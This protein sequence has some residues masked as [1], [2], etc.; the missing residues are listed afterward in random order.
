MRSLLDLVCAG[1]VRGLN[2]IFHLLPIEFTLWLARRCSIIVYF[3]NRPRRIVAYTNLRAAFC[4]G[5]SPDELRKLTKRVYQGLA[6]VFLEIVSLT[7][8]NKKYVEKYVEIVGAENFYKIKDH[9]NGIIFLT[10][11][12]GNWELSG[13]VSALMGF[14]LIVLARE[15]NM[16]RLDNL[17]NRLRRS[18]G[19]VVVTK[20][21]TIKYIV[22]ALHSG[23]IIGMLGDQNAG[24]TGQQVEF[25]G[26]PAAT[27]PGTVRIAAKTGAYV[28]PV[29]TARLRGPYH[30]LMVGEPISIKKNEDTVPYLEKYNKLLEK[31]ITMYPDQ[32]LWL[33]KRWK[34]STVKK[35]V[36]LSDGKAGHL[37]QSL[38]L[39]DELKR[40]R[41]KANY[42]DEDTKVDVVDVKF[43]NKLTK[44]LL[45]IL[46]V[47]SGR[48]C[49]GCMRCLRFCM[50]KDSYDDLMKRYADVVISCGSAAAAVNRFFSMENNAKSAAVMRPAMPG[51]NKFDMVVLPCHD[52]ITGRAGRHVIR[53]EIVP[54]LINEERMKTASDEIS[55]ITRLKSSRTIGV[56]L[57]G[58][59]S[60]FVL[61]SA[62]TKKL[63]K[64][65][66]R[67]SESS[68]ADLLFTTSRRT[69]AEAAELIK[70]GLSSC[71]R[72]RLLVVANEKN[73]PYAASGIL[74][75]SDTV[76]ISCESASMVSE[77]VQSGKTVI[78]FR[79]KKKRKNKSK[80]EKMLRD[81]E[82]KGYI[83]VV[84]PDKISNAICE[85]LRNPKR[86]TAPRAMHDVY[87]NMWR[88]GV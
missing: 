86:R 11:H 78:V 50:R 60:D 81:L 52:R 15:Q 2:L 31:Y 23:K 8:V 40:Y 16:K 12:F 84:E 4:A 21:I 38:A 76:V 22:K 73:V 3:L 66:L 28:L 51:L 47:F 18:K 35:V 70:T 45:Q 10:A 57:G 75:L 30:R 61:T 63:L 83:T 82:K 26:R 25:F 53:T 85:N 20:G 32:W 27:A 68:D 87:M 29:F 19:L 17:L 33:H 58:N 13:V 37:N 6:Q 72:C 55:K 41:R 36:V 80:F 42:R 1:L 46:S 77:A 59:N 24:K 9:P 65:I 67:A 64:E 88:L 62:I 71:R 54:N 5:K 48:R 34:A 7:K 49:Q 74:G 79:L 43:K 69:P 44:A 14:P 56:L 39:C